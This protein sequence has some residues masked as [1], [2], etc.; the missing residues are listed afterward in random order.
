[1]PAERTYSTVE[2]VPQ[3]QLTL[4]FISP[5]MWPP[6]RPDFNSVD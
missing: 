3:E 1:M 5:E 4:G 2:F 6:N